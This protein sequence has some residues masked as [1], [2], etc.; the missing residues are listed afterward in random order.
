MTCW[1]AWASANA[2]KYLL[3]R[4]G[5]C[6]EKKNDYYYYQT[7]IFVM[8]NCESGWIIRS[9][10]YETKTTTTNTSTF[11]VLVQTWSQIRLRK[12]INFIKVSIGVK[13]FQF[14]IQNSQFYIVNS[15]QITPQQQYSRLNKFSLFLYWKEEKLVISN[16]PI[17]IQSIFRSMIHTECDIKKKKKINTKSNVDY[18]Q[19]IGYYKHDSNRILN[20]MILN[21]IINCCDFIGIVHQ[22]YWR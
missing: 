5:F 21:W 19:F 16:E 10:V 7:H 6:T 1:F 20:S 3:T 14:C 22:L 17:F 15:F 11:D 4:S 13:K 18:G 9:I 2:H 12:I 8:Y